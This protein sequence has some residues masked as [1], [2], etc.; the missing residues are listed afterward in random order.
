MDG[1][2]PA[3]LEELRA[4][5]GDTEPLMRDVEAV[6]V[7][8][9]ERQF[10]TQSGPGG[11]WPALT[12]TTLELRARRG[13]AGSPM[14]QL[15]AGGLAASVQGGHTDAAAWVSSNKPYAAMQFFGGVTSPQSMIPN[16]R[17]SARPYMPFD[18]ATDQL[19][20]EAEET[21]MDVLEHH[22]GRG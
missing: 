22:I 13:V 8:V 2:A 14:L 5:L 19:T 6:L 18:T 20:P 7:S 9:S 10:Q 11:P 16:R 1:A 4:A 3:T 17:I 21:I 12:E 15:S